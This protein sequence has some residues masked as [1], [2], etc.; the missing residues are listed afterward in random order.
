MSE[1]GS[2][3]SMVPLRESP[4]IHQGTRRDQISKTQT[5]TRARI[6]HDSDSSGD[7]EFISKRPMRVQ[8][9]TLNRLA[10]DLAEIDH[11]QR[12]GVL[13]EIKAFEAKLSKYAGSHTVNDLLTQLVSELRSLPKTAKRGMSEKLKQVRS[14]I[15]S[16]EDHMSREKPRSEAEKRLHEAR[17]AIT[18]IMQ[19][20]GEYRSDE[21]ETIKEKLSQIKLTSVE[22]EIREIREE[23]TKMDTIIAEN[24]ELKQ[25][26]EKLRKLQ[27]SNAA[28]QRRK[29]CVEM[30]AV[31]CRI[32]ALQTEKKQGG[33]SE[34][35]AEDLEA[36]LEALLE[37][38]MDL[39]RRMMS[40]K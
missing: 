32:A 38:Q 36:E 4:K 2:G 14:L 20:I 33:L 11:D 24:R 8:S 16:I 31:Q 21:L 7:E 30:K 3:K 13:L 15:H 9:P 19:Q 22:A 6:R 10:N 25:E 40:L 35:D 29:V 27:D 28:S 39:I 12:D 37:Q 1:L 23:L 26:C 5:L 34:T 18:N 17:S